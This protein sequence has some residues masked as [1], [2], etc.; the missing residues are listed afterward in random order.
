MSEQ[1]PVPLGTNEV[2]GAVVG[3]ALAYLFTSQ[4]PGRTAAIACGA[5]AVLLSAFR[6]R[7]THPALWWGG[8]GAVAGSIIGTSLSLDA[9]LAA[10]GPARRATTRYLGTAIL[11]VAGLISGI[12]IGKDAEHPDIPK[13]AEFLKR[14]SALTVVLYA[15]IVTAEFPFQ[16]LDAVRALSSRLSTMTTILVT[17]LAVPGWI[18]FRIGARWGARLRA[19]PAQSGPPVDGGVGRP[20][21]VP[22]Q[23]SQ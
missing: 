7:R 18:G 3:G 9:L 4:I 22:G 21:D 17:T 13:P 10:E 14:A 1:R 5:V 15:I 6:S 2:V 12:F 23:P 16:G 20:E 19:R 8:V 11:A